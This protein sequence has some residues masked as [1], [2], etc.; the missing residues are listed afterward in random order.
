MVGVLCFCRNLKPII[1]SIKT[2]I[3]QRAWLNLEQTVQFLL[4]VNIRCQFTVEKIT[5]IFFLTRRFNF[6]I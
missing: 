5:D 4:Q 6:I 1:S 3:K 2:S